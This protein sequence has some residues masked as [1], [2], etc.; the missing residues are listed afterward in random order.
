[1]H[2]AY[3][4]HI[5]NIRTSRMVVPEYIEEVKSLRNRDSDSWKLKKSSRV[6]HTQGIEHAA[7]D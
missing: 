2:G 6:V 7:Y 4:D 3:G 1:M 5:D